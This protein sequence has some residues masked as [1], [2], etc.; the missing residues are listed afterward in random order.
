MFLNFFDELTLCVDEK[1]KN[2]NK[3]QTMLKIYD[4]ANY[5]LNFK[6]AD[7]LENRNAEEMLHCDFTL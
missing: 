4:S 2:E 6:H 1:D 5:M 7:E 3:E